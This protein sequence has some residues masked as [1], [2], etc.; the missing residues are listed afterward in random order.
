MT[1]KDIWC[2]K[3]RAGSNPEPFLA[4]KGL[5]LIPKKH[6]QMLSGNENPALGAFSF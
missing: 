3:G 5:R 4:K 2:P 1:S 6:L